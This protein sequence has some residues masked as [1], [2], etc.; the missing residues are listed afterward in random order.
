MKRE[1]FCD[2]MGTAPLY[3]QLTYIIR[4]ARASPGKPG[5]FSS[6]VVK[7]VRTVAKAR[8][9]KADAS[10]REPSNVK[11]EKETMLDNVIANKADIYIRVLRYV[12][13]VLL[14]KLEMP[15]GDA[16]F[17]KM[18]TEPVTRRYWRQRCRKRRAF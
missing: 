3:K 15:A 12:H 10:R 13:S 1:R 2:T 6:Y 17:E 14:Y 8:V 11:K 9:E 5:I 4:L 7:R 18:R 16:T